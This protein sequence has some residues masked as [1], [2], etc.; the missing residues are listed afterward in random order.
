MFNTGWLEA[1]DRMK[2]RDILALLRKVYTQSIGVEFMHI[3]DSKKRFWLEERLEGCG[4]DY[5]IS[6]EEQL[7]ILEML[8]AA[9]GLEKFLHTRY[10]GQKRFSLEGGES[11]IPLLHETVYACW[12]QWRRRGGHRHGAPRATQRAGQYPGQVAGRAV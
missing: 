7:R 12:R 4:G 6:R 2:L 9:E 11:L 8:T 5:Q 10:V 1:P 3:V